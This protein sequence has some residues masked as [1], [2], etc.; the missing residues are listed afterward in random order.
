MVASV[1]AL[2]HPQI[3][4][5]NMPH[6]LITALGICSQS[7][8]SFQKGVADFRGRPRRMSLASSETMRWWCLTNA[9]GQ[10]G[11]RFEIITIPTRLPPPL[12]LGHCET[13]TYTNIL[14]ISKRCVAANN[15]HNNK[16]HTPQT[17]S[18]LH[19]KNPIPITERPQLPFL[20]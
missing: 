9:S 15:N 10:C 5:Q 6:S 16:E 13:R 14:S 17:I 11:C 12:S 7:P 2:R 3:C 19:F 8:M 18:M 4:R 1:W 20:H